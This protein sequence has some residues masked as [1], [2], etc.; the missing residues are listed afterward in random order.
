VRLRAGVEDPGALVVLAQGAQHIGD[1]QDR[2]H[3]IGRL[4]PGQ[5]EVVLIEAGAVEAVQRVQLLLEV[6]VAFQ[7]LG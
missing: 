7:L 4:V 1:G 6:H 2:P 3:L 5:Q